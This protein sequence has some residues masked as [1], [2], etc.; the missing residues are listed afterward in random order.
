MKRT[1]LVLA[2]LLAAVG[3]RTA[4]ASPV[5][6]FEHDGG[7]VSWV[8][9]EGF[10]FAVNT[11]G[12]SL[13]PP[14][15]E[16][17]GDLVF[18]AG[19]ADTVSPNARGGVDFHF[20]DGQIA[21]DFGADGSAVIPVLPFTISL[22]AAVYKQTWD[23]WDPNALVARMLLYPHLS[24]GSGMLDA[25]LAHRLG[26]ERQTL[27][28]EAFLVIDD[29]LPSPSLEDPEF[30]DA[31]PNFINGRIAVRQVPEPQLLSLLIAGGMAVVRR[32]RRRR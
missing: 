16:L 10:N 18:T 27:G 9:A 11:A 22:S 23:N 32:Q 28:G 12:A 31:V 1:W 21:F 5:M 24:L 13:Q 14:R 2:L 8:G 19:A 29:F 17:F 26:V 3:E 20:V 30:H 15:L 7:G 4:A 6:Y 25:R